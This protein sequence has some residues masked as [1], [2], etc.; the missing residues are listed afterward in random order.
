MRTSRASSH[1]TEAISR[2]NKIK[3]WKRQK[4]NTSLEKKTMTEESPMGEA[5]NKWGL[6]NITVWQVADRTMGR[7]Y[8]LRIY[9]E[10]KDFFNHMEP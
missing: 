6:T 7:E 1:G 3:F 9:P 4:N 10:S 5:L 2:A 8:V